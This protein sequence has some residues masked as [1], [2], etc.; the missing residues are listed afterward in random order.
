MSAESALRAAIDT[1]ITQN[2]KLV[3]E[4]KELFTDD[5][6]AEQWIAHQVESSDEMAD[7]D[8][9]LGE[10][11]SDEEDVATL[12]R[13]GQDDADDETGNTQPTAVENETEV[14]TLASYRALADDPAVEGITHEDLDR[15]LQDPDFEK[16]MT[17]AEAQVDAALAEALA[18]IESD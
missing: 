10:Q 17:A 15:M 3:A 13:V 18:S 16:K 1:M 8:R 7:L 6:V 9:E 12:R 4:F 5:A 11:P 2:S 14:D